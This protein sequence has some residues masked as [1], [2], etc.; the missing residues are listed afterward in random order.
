MSKFS[1]RYVGPIDTELVAIR[2]DIKTANFSRVAAD[3]S[4]VLE[5]GKGR[6]VLYYNDD[7]GILTH[8]PLGTTNEGIIRFACG[9]PNSSVVIQMVDGEVSKVFVNAPVPVFRAVCARR[10]LELQSQASHG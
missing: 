8:Q 3:T 4:V 5:F 2:S 1:P 9:L 7:A 10:A 6:Q